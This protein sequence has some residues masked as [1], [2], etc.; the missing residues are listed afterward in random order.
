MEDSAGGKDW[1]EWLERES[2]NVA[3]HCPPRKYAAAAPLA[4][5]AY[6]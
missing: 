2:L 1:R 4:C 6:Y 3:T 5:G